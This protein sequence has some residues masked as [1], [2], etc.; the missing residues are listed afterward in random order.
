MD[1]ASAEKAAVR[2]KVLEDKLQSELVYTVDGKAVSAQ[3]AHAIGADKIATMEVSKSG[4]GG[5]SKVSITTTGQYKTTSDSGARIVTMRNTNTGAVETFNFKTVQD[6]KGS[7]LV[8]IDGV[9]SSQGAL[10]EI[11]PADIVTIDVLKN[12]AATT[13]YSNPAAANGVIKVV[14][15]RANNPEARSSALERATVELKLQKEREV[16]ARP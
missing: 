15:K 11:N 13:A 5:S 14:T 12:A 9:E 2:A 6:P 3:E 8:I 16:S 10:K 1:V 4:V 7:P